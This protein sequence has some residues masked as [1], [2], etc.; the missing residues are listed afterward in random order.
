MTPLRVKSGSIWV[1]LVR[2]IIR[3][4]IQSVSS[5]VICAKIHTFNPS[6]IQSVNPLSKSLP[7]CR[8]TMFGRQ[9]VWHNVGSFPKG[10]DKKC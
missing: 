9:F 1:H 8:K 5:R 6:R 7:L 10:R 4:R 3:L 2:K